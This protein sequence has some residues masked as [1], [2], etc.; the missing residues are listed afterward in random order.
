MKTLMML[1]LAAIVMMGA[2]RALRGRQLIEKRKAAK[3][4]LNK[5]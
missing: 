2:C 1:A 4:R 3:Q 5:W